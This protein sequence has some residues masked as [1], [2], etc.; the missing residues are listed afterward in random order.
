M[1]IHYDTEQ[2][3]H[4]IK[5]LFN[6]TGVSISVL[7]RDYR[8]LVHFSHP[9][10]FCSCL[11]Q[12]EAGS[13][14][15]K[16]CDHHILEKCSHSRKLEGHICTAGLY[17]SA[18]PIIKYGTIV[19]YVILGRIRSLK[20]SPHLP[21]ADPVIV[22]KLKKLYMQLPVMTEKQLEALYALLPSILFHDA[23]QIVYDPQVS[24]IL[25]YIQRNLTEDLSVHALCAEFHI[26]ANHLYNAFREN[27]DQTVNDYITEQRL[28][29]AKDLLCSSAD[30]VY[31]IA[32][33]VGIGNY[34]YFCKLFK[35]RNNCTPM[36][37]RKTYRC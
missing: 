16:Q 29:L 8:I 14:H 36:Q 15:C 37:Y 4:L 26:S 28:S 13:E 12:L 5:N 9:D 25:D 2:L 35:K 20:T 10:D 11:Q 23:I 3:G 33:R 27:L 30:P 32:E 19:G 21:N 18:M 7:D 31:V 1:I 6:L 24:E 22:K 17:D 34:T